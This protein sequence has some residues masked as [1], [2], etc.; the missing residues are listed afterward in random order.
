MRRKVGVVEAAMK[1]KQIVFLV[2]A[3]L[4]L[5]GV[6]A[7]YDMPRQEFPTFT[8]RQGLVVG[9]YPGAT[10]T[11]VEQ[12]L[13]TQVE[14]YLFSFK[15]VN[16]AK[17]YSH[18]RDGL[19]VIYVTLNDNVTNS[20]EFWSKLSYGLNNFKA[21]LPS[22]VLALVADNNFGDTSALLITLESKNKNYRDLETYLYR[23]EDQLRRIPSV[24]NVRHYGLE[25]EQIAV[26]LDKNKLDKYG[27]SSNTLFATLFSQGLRTVG[28]EVDN[29]KTDVPIHVV[30]Q[31]QTEQDVANQI[32]YSDP[33]GAVIRLKDVARIVREYPQ[34]DSYIQINGNKCLVVSMEMLP[35]HNIVK[36]GKDVEKVLKDF[37]KR[38]PS[39]VT[40]HRVV[41]QPQVVSDSITTFLKEFLFAI[42]AVIL[43]T[44]LLL[45]LRVASVAASSIPITIFISLGIMDIFGMELNTVTLAGLI[46]VL[47]MIVDNSVV[48]VDDYLQK[49]DQGM[50]R[51]YASIASAKEFFSAIFAAT[52]AISITFF[53]FLLTLKGEFR[54]FVLM[55]P[56]TVTITL[57]VSL[58]VAMLVIPYLQYHFIDKGFISSNPEPKKKKFDSLKW[59]Q[60]TYEKFLSR[61]FAHPKRTLLIGA[62]TIVAGMVLFLFVP[63]RLMPVA[64]RNQFAVEIY[65][66]DGSSLQQTALVSDSLENMLRKDQRVKSITS[67]IGT[68]SPRFQTAYAPNFP[69]KNYAQFIV[70]TISNEAT[71]ELLDAYS[72]K[73]SRYFPN[74]YVRFKQLDF[75][76]VQALIEVRLSGNNETNL[77]QTGDSLMAKMRMLPSLRWVHTDFETQQPIAKV[78]LNNTVANQLGITQAMVSSQ[79]AVRF[80]GLPMTTIWEK[81]YPVS[82]VLKADNPGNQHLTDVNNT[83]IHSVL[84]GVSVPLRQIATV[85]P[86]WTQGQLV[87]RNGIP[88]LTVM[89]DVARGLNTNNVFDQVKK[90][91]ETVRLPQGITLSYGGAHESDATTLPQIVEG[92][93]ASLMIIFLIL[94]FHFKRVKLA[95][96]V[97]GSAAL[98]LFGAFFG[99]LV[100]HLDFSIT[101]ILGIVSLVGIIVRNGMIMLDYAE[102]LRF[103]HNEPVLNAA[104]DAGKRR[105]R[106]IFLTSAAASMGV[107]P[108]ILSHSLLWSPM[109]AVIFFGTFTS[110][111][112]VV[113]ILPVAYWWMYRHDERVLPDEPIS[114]NTIP[115]AKPLIIFLLLIGAG[116]GNMMAQKT[117]N[118]EQCKQLA[119]TNNSL[120]KDASLE[121]KVAK[122]VKAS[123]LTQYFPSVSASMG[124]F[125][126]DKPLLKMSVPGGN[127]PVYNGNLST[128]A[129]ATQYAYFPGMN[130]NYFDKG[131]VSAV[132]LTQPIFAGG[133]IVNKNKLAAIGVAV[134]QAKEKL[135]QNEVVL[136]TEESFW[137]VISLQ[138]K[139]KTLQ[140]YASFLDSLYKQADDAYHAGLIN[141]NDVM[142]VTLKKSELSM[143]RLKLEH[144]ITLSKMAL[145][146]YIGIPYD[147]S[148]SFSQNIDS[149]EPPESVYA[150]PEQALPNRQEYKLLQ[151]NVAAQKLQTSIK[152]GSYLPQIGIGVS[153]AYYN[154]STMKDF[155]T[156]AFVS[157]KVPL[158]DW[159]EASHAIKERHLKEQIAANDLKN[160][161]ELLTLQMQKAWDELV[162][163]YAQIGV[164]NVTIQQAEENLKINQDNFHAGIVNVSDMLE[165]EAMLQQAQN[166]LIDA[167][168]AYKTKRIAYLQVI[169][170]N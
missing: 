109:G 99:V 13:T 71:V 75:E 59:I 28:G 114:S 6:F 12:Q 52:L 90:V 77:M 88:T 42:L 140:R 146:Q 18:S 137:Q 165:A 91:A 72:D 17:T 54:D 123:A 157:V 48:I 161:A 153:E 78:N 73:Y 70:N 25:K 144:G 86:S 82:V 45:P 169:G 37:Q 120:V 23:L 150:N 4:I 103:K 126:A 154:F 164:A 8:I 68:S 97:F 92:L 105:M 130:L 142:K 124:G 44:M 31:Y 136:H 98:S 27:I 111:I 10:A 19:M 108:M 84:P 3:A 5:I 167:Q 22:G 26:Y 138:E 66:P 80:N 58:L 41:N 34:P 65:L 128:L 168:T 85:T 15:E 119:I 104:M 112:L 11:E 40:M 94:M 46:V 20:D 60:S 16:K 125:L 139:M 151:Q 7:L 166:Q 64:E 107:I 95:L 158:T 76:P 116:M 131:L 148:I 30:S 36:Y 110:M 115:Y 133:R 49:L 106:P 155:N 33:T 50:S 141:R 129:N 93:L 145:C 162:E 121:V 43:V 69:S 96:L 118:L 14:R 134:N 24:S 170:K 135:A 122:Q 79:L 21:Q 67:F 102:G 51:W 159:W 87:R 55:F 89:A 132:T 83:Y 2:V 47:G 39:G 57:G 100:L 101:S 147:A 56:W 117:Y 152:I 81:D 62:L 113:L 61:A 160:N 1:Y 35:G 38:L 29:G 149:I 163:A 156:L 32:I 143:N 53:P 9:V 127:L 63:Q 74:A